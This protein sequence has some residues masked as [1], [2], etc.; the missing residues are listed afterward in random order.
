M[1]TIKTYINNSDNKVLN[2][3]LEFIQDLEGDF[4]F[5]NSIL[6]PTIDIEGNFN[7]DFEYNVVYDNDIEISYIEDD[8]EF[9]VTYI[10]NDLIT[11]INYIYI[12]IFKKYYY[13]L[14]I[15]ILNK[16]LFRFTTSIDVLMSHKDEILN[17]YAIVER[18][19]F[20]YDD[21][22]E[23]RERSY[24][25]KNDVELINIDTSSNTFNFNQTPPV[26]ESTYLLTY[27]TFVADNENE[28]VSNVVENNLPKVTSSMAG[29][30]KFTS[31]V[32]LAQPTLAVL[33]DYVATHESESSFIISII[34]YP[35]ELPRLNELRQV[36]LGNNVV[37]VEYEGNTRFCEGARLQKDISNYYLLGKFKINK[38]SYLDVEP[39]STYEIYLPFVDYVTLK[40]SDIL[41]YEIRI[42]YVFDFANGT[43]KAIIYNHDLDYVISSYNAVIGISIP[44]NRTNAQQLNDAK[45]QAGIN[46]ATSTL[47]GVIGGA[48]KGGVVGAV[49]GG[50]AGA[51]VSTI[52]T[53]ETLAFMHDKAT[54]SMRS[55][56]DGVYS[57]LDIFIKKTKYV[58]KDI[59][60]Y[61]AYFGKP[62]NQRYKL[63]DLTGY[64]KISD[65]HLDNLDA[66]NNEKTLIEN[67]LKEGIIL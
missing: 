66:T 52:K 22:L 33:S 67:L 38:T 19:E 64:T 41:G 50:V 39:Y 60:D 8:E 3:N 21:L 31:Y 6:T 47:A 11:T 46:I 2:K 49:I 56:F 18:N 32:T 54:T 55:G 13:V 17:Q 43:A 4:R 14:D 5:E 40:S 59:N 29:Y 61:A 30:S 37:K 7:F 42:Y 48:V 53:V 9:D 15:V 63:S 25:F 34:A 23:D 51:T 65:I 16:N 12:P 62:L 10:L 27:F 1:F 28:N 57:T 24:E 20:T 58:I 36:Y 44:V 26:F 45:I 35:F